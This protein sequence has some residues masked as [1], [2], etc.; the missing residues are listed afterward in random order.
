MPLPTS[1]GPIVLGVYAVLLAVGGIMGYV[2]AGSRPS[3]IAGVA[4]SIL[5]LLFLVLT[6][7]GQRSLGQGLGVALALGLL[8]F[9]SRRFTTNRKFMPGGLMALVS[10]VVVILLA[11]LLVRGGSLGV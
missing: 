3:L 4:C 10:L 11:A 2:K 6:L 1:I 9:F 8:G 7:M 5:C